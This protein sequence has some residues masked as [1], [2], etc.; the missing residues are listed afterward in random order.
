MR[1]VE[2]R[3]EGSGNE[4]ELKWI[5]VIEMPKCWD[6]KISSK[7][8]IFEM[9][10]ISHLYASDSFF[11]NNKS[12]VQNLN[13]LM[14]FTAGSLKISIVENKKRNRFF[15]VSLFFAPPPPRFPHFTRTEFER[16]ENST[17]NGYEELAPSKPQ[18]HSSSW[19]TERSGTR[20][21]VALIKFVQSCPW[22]CS[23]C[24]PFVLLSSLFSSVSISISCVCVSYFF[25]AF[26]QPRPRLSS[27]YR[28]L[29]QTRLLYVCET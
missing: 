1:K 11:C 29:T 9:D 14:K 18:E 15:V 28:S 8:V 23:A 20:R 2:V 19:S 5:K 7:N 24:W 6:F 13:I 17:W 3:D 21:R 27:G 16:E 25:F 26:N 12:W 22:V 4:G 10:H